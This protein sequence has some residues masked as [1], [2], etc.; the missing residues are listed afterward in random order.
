MCCSATV[1]G[2]EAHL[3]RVEVD[4]SPGLFTFQ[5]V[6]LPQKSVQ[7]AKQRVFSAIS[8]SGFDFPKK[9]ITVNLAPA[10]LPKNGTYYD[11]PIA[12]GILSAS[13]QLNCEIEDI[14]FTGE[15]SL[16]GKVRSTL[17]FFPI[18]ELAAQSKTKLFFPEENENE[19]NLLEKSRLYPVKSLP[20]LIESLS[21]NRPFPT[22][23]S[24]R[25]HDTKPSITFDFADVKG[26]NEAKRALEIAAAGGHNLL[27]VGSPGSGKSLMAK[28]F[29]SILPPLGREEMIELMKIRSISNKVPASDSDLRPF[30]SPHHTI[31]HTALVGGGTYP[32]PGE[33][34]LS[35]RGIL[36]LDEFPEFPARSLE[37][38]RQPL[39]DKIITVSRTNQ[40]ITF[41]ANFTLIAAM[42]PCK[43]GW[44]GDDSHE[45]ICTQH[46]IEK[47]QQRISGPIIDR[48]DLRVQVNRLP[49]KEFRSGK[50]SESSAVIRQRVL[51]ARSIQAQRFSNK[52]TYTTN[53][54]MTSADIERFI[55]LTKE[56]EMLLNSAIEKIKGSARSYFRIQKVSRTIADL[57][58]SDTVKE[59]HIAE[60]LSYR[61]DF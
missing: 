23:A 12:V 52:K 7:E 58:N 37:S 22:F 42:N 19:V 54:D 6:G 8:N 30:R 36:F 28:A 15:L 61:L 11:L 34:T 33:I 32:Q 57:E 51:S 4:I 39:E 2:L 31:S 26:Q 53:D 45:C 10:H 49:V 35:H 27:M 18:A 59:R 29:S 9:K 17:G 43:C 41:P 5:I 14:M 60:A 16:E 40:V 13:D 38:L 46:E 55:Y 44:Y 21:G 48:I 50:R 56:A 20:S 1:V 47:Y 3:V 24:N 25:N